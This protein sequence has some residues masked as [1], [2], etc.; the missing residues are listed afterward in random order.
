MV[1]GPQMKSLVLT[2]TNW[3]RYKEHVSPLLTVGEIQLHFLARRLVVYCAWLVLA[4][5][6]NEP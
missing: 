4:V 3:Q 6:Y 1:Y 2:K 5:P